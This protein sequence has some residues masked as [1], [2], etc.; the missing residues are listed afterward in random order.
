[1][2]R[3]SL[4]VQFSKRK[5]FQTHTAYMVTRYVRRQVWVEF[6]ALSW[7]WKEGAGGCHYAPTGATVAWSTPPADDEPSADAS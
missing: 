7:S 3:A 6:G 5:S 1:M 2:P 4:I